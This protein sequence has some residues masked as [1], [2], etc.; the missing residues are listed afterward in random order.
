MALD[1]S[2]KF[3]YATLGVVHV[4]QLD[5][6]TGAMMLETVSTFEAGFLPNAI[7]VIP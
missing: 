5:P 6:D 7:V 4:L 1:P 3:L 2:G